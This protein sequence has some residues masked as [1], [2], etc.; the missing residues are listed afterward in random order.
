MHFKNI[1]LTNNAIRMWFSIQ[2]FIERAVPE[3]NKKK[4]GT[5]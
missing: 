4:G 2:F 5:F 3:L 1:L